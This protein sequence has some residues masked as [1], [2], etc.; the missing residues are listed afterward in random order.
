MVEE[1]SRA[2]REEWI[3]VDASAGLALSICKNTIR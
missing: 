3:D 1:R 2:G